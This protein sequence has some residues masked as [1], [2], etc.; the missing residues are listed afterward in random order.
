[1]KKSLSL[2][3][4][5]GSDNFH[6]SMAGANQHLTV[7]IVGMFSVVD[8]SSLNITI[9]HPNGT[10]ATISHIG[11]LK[12]TNN[13]MLYDFLMVHGYCVSLLFVNKLIRD[14]KMFVSFDE[15]KCYILDLTMQ[16]ILGTGSESEGLYLFDMP[17]KCS[18][19]ESNMAMSF[20]VSKLL[21]HNRLGHPADQVLATLHNNLKFSKSAF[22]HVCEVCYK[23]K[24]ARELFPLSD[25]KSK[26]LG[27]LVHLDL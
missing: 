14:S 5:N 16:K 18:L 3:N 6:A 10:L 19:G 9:S 12:L 7:S 15:E 24:Q 1:M 20:N 21:W 2:I 23:A 11:N 17:P 26:K 22:V 27:E 25:H 4:D 13:I 8:V